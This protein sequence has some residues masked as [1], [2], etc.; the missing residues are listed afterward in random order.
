MAEAH[1]EV[2]DLAHMYDGEKVVEVERL[3]IR[4]GNTLALIGPNGSGKSTLLRLIGLLERPTSGRIIIGGAD[5]WQT[6]RVLHCRRKMAAVFQE[7]LLF[8]GSVFD[9]VAYGL[10]LRRLGKAEIARRVKRALETVGISH[11]AERPPNK[12]SGGEAQRASLARA[13]AIEPEILL[14]DEPF[15]SLDPPTSE[16]LLEDFQ[17]ILRDA[18]ITTVFV[19]HSREEALALG[20]EIAVM[21][22]GSIKQMGSPRDVFE[23]PASPDVADIVGADN[24]L[25]GRITGSSDGLV[26]IKVDGG[27]IEAISDASTGE[28]V[29]ACVRPEDVILFMDGSELAEEV[30]RS[31]ARNRFRGRVISVTNFGPLSRVSIEARFKL[32]ALVTKRSAEEM[33]LT[34]GAP[35]IAA[36]KATGVHVMRREGDER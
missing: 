8:S 7:P 31:S 1:I 23:K 35:V 34:P 16:S 4:R 33:K 11:L 27:E 13:L 12:I 6:G 29:L 10:K 28:E 24:R 9:N 25:H 20:D 36:F 26:T 3:S 2:K 18:R 30:L 14:L 15:A 5:P 32:T 19:T 17:S 22:S 21:V